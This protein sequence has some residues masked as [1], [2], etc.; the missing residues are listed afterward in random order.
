MQFTEDNIIGITFSTSNSPG[1]YS[2]YKVLEHPG[3]PT[4]VKL[5]YT[6]HGDKPTYMNHSKQNLI[7]ELNKGTY[8]IIS[9]PESIVNN[10]EIF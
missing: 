3:D 4:M 6:S 7:I 5:E 8:T 1:K 10:Y 9:T 2:T